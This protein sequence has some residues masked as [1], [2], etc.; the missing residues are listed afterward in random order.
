MSSYTDHLAALTIIS[1]R[2]SDR[3]FSKPSHINMGSEGTTRFF[4]LPFETNNSWPF[5]LHFL[6]ESVKLILMSRESNFI[7]SV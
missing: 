2:A 7:H 5:S 1:Q 6:M 3:F 4:L